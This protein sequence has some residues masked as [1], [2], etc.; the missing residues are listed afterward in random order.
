[1]HSCDYLVIGSGIAGLSFAL[2]A[3]AHGTVIVLTKEG[4]GEANT[5]YAQ[6]GVAAVWTDE[7]SFDKHVEDTLVAGDGLCDPDAVKLTV[8]EG[9]AR[10]RELI[11]IGV[12]FTRNADDEEY[13]LG[14]EGGHS[15]RRILHAGDITGASIQHALVRSASE[16]PNIEIRDQHIGLDLITTDDDGGGGGRVLGAYALDDNTG[17]VA[18]FHGRSVIL[19]TGGFGKVYLY[20]SN[21]DVAT[22]DGHAMA[23]RAGAV[24]GNMEFVQFHP[25]CLYHPQ[26]KNFLISEALRGEGGILIRKDGTPFMNGV[27]AL[28]SLA[29]R[30]IVARAIDRELKESGDDCVYLDMTHLSRDF[31]EQRF[32]NIHAKCLGFGIDMVTQ[33]IP[34]VPAAHYACGGAVVSEHGA[35]SIEGLYAIGE[36]SCTGLHGANRLASNSLLEA[37]VYAHRAAIHATAYVAASS[38]S[39]PE[40]AEWNDRSARDPEEQVIVSQNWDEIRRFMWNYVGIVRSNKRLLRARRRIDTLMTEIHQYYWDYRIFRNLIELRNIAAVA[41]MIVESALLRRESRGLHFNLDYP[42]KS[43]RLQTPT[44]LT[45]RD[46]G[47]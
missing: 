7:D 28:R 46:I 9:P 23:F 2:K 8:H 26:A 19:A 31:V 20:T 37:V 32:P 34:V 41:T 36:V 43:E 24:M 39:T 33:P 47:L 14:R 10:V 40:L 11:E 5:R 44:T 21:P 6:G 35:S 22:G 15:E 30:D 3:A 1:M 27:H 29:P 16:H 18:T 4:R 25:T 13:D 42:D 38:T 45:R 17:Q 12:A